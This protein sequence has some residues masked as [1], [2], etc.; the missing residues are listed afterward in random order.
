[1]RYYCG[2]C[3]NSCGQ[4]YTLAEHY[5]DIHGTTIS[6]AT[7]AALGRDEQNVNSVPKHPKRVH[8][9]IR[10]KCTSVLSGTYSFKRHVIDIHKSTDYEAHKAPKRPQKP[11]KE[12]GKQLENVAFKIPKRP[13]RHKKKDTSQSTE[14]LN[15][16][17]KSHKPTRKLARK[18]LENAELDAGDVV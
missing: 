9:K 2:L 3:G 14:E 10:C 11:K 1:M 4:P 17:E 15:V 8:T 12:S 18:K 7:A 5:R 13:K 6:S 16:K